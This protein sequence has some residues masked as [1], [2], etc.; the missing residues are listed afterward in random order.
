M[1][2]QLKAGKTELNVVNDKLGTPTYTHDFAANVKVLLEKEFWGLYN[3]VCE[4]LTEP[5]RSGPRNGATAGASRSRNHQRGRFVLFRQ[6]VFCSCVPDSER[7]I[8]RKLLLRGVNVMRDWRIGLEEY[9]KGYYQ[10]Y[11]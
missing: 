7:L 5:A 2:A 3:M 9:V 1:M 11:L 8:N 6:G 4:G 10:D